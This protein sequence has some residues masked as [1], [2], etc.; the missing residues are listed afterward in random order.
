[1]SNLPT[2]GHQ[3]LKCMC[4]SFASIQF[5]T[6]EFQRILDFGTVEQIRVQLIKYQ[7]VEHIVI[8]T[9][10]IAYTVGTTINCSSY[11]LLIVDGQH[12][13]E[14][15]RCECLIGNHIPFT[16][17]YAMLDRE[18]AYEA[19]RI[20]SLNR[21]HS[22]LS[23]QALSEQENIFYK[24]CEVKINSIPGIKIGKINCNRPAVDVITLIKQ[25]KHNG[26]YDIDK[27]WDWINEKNQAIYDN[28]RRGVYSGDK[29]SDSIIQK[30]DDCRV[31][32]GLIKSSSYHLINLL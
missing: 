11:D 19:Y 23:Q 7:G 32:F 12:R 9:P 17:E 24:E 14:A 28:H 16:F 4:S 10:Y 22:D 3:T 21:A 20:R 29:P 1:M 2:H 18:T 5:I 8:G 31:Y 30:C 13:I 6:P 25:Y 26:I 15:L 27:F